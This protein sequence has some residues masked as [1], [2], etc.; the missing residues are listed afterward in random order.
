MKEPT[1]KTTIITLS[2]IGSVCIG[3]GIG[4]GLTIHGLGLFKK[5]VGDDAY[6]NLASV[7]MTDS[8]SLFDRYKAIKDK[9][10]DFTTV[11]SEQELANLSLYLFD[12]HENSRVTS[13]GLSVATIGVRQNIWAMS[14]RE[15]ARFFEES[16]SKSSVVA[17]HDRMYQEGDS[18][19]YYFTG[20]PY[21]GNPSEG[22]FANSKGVT[23]SNEEYAEFLGRNVSN[24]C[25]YYI[26]ENTV[27]KDG[28]L[29]RKNKNSGIPTSMTKVEDGYKVELEL[30]NLYGVKNYVKQMK[31]I[32]NLYQ[33]PIFEYVHLTFELDSSLEIKFMHVKEKYYAKT[34]AVLGSDLEATMSIKFETDGDFKIPELNDVIEYPESF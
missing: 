30:D 3:L 28:A 10:D 20:T 25:I 21:E 33:Y 12:L 7:E 14:I 11:F 29:N 18:T 13:L 16:K 26:N 31:G 32:S 17:I 4:A 19:T 15:G 5:D 9:T 34:S 23:I 24:P 6:A 2:I 22:D 8:D 1:K 27:I